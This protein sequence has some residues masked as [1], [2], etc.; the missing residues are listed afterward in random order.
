MNRYK[1]RCFVYEPSNKLLTAISNL[2]FTHHFIIDRSWENG[3]H[4]VLRGVLNPRYLSE[5]ATHLERGVKE[6]ILEY[7]EDEFIEKYR[8]INNLLNKNEEALKTII[9]GQVIVEQEEKIF[10]NAMVDSLFM[11]INSILDRYFFK[12]YFKSNSLYKV[13]EEMWT[14][15]REL[16]KYEKYGS[17]DAYNCHLSHY[18]AFIHKLDEDNKKNIEKKFN[19]KFLEDYAVGKFNFNTSE[20]RLTN[21]LIGFYR[22]IIPLV[23]EKRLNFY[24]PYDRNFIENNMEYASSR[25]QETFSE[26]NIENHLYN[27]VLIVNRWVTNALYKKILLMKLTNLDRFY[28]NYSISRLVYPEYELKD[29]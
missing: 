15:H 9:K 8:S 17:T 18:I 11:Q 21:D 20:S 6:S 16:E 29:S 5:I 3:H 2:I 7:N 26:E 14:F 12:F 22:T 10:D 1:I 24:M 28:M 19:E 13:I 25:H 23:K 27:D 4:I